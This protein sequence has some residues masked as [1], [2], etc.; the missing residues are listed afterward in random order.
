MG[1]AYGAFTVRVR[2]DCN[3][4]DDTLTGLGLDTTTGGCDVAAPGSATH[5]GNCKVIVTSAGTIGS[6]TRTI[7][8]VISRI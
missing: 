4:G 7:S 3:A 8:V 1:S 2:N 6:T 5:D